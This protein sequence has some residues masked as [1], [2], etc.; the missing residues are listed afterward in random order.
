MKKETIQ[1]QPT[2]TLLQSY[3]PSNWYLV[4]MV[5]AISLGSYITFYTTLEKYPRYNDTVASGLLIL[6]LIYF[7]LRFL[8][9]YNFNFYQT[10]IVAYQRIGNKRL[11]IPYQDIENYT[12]V[13]KKDK[14]RINY[15]LHFKTIDNQ[16]FKICS[17]YCTYPKAF[18]QIYKLVKKEAKKDIN[19]SNKIQRSERRELAYGLILVSSL[20]LFLNYEIY[21]D[22]PEQAT[23]KNTVLI[24]GTVDI[25]EH[26]KQRSHYWYDLKLIE[27]P[28]FSFKIDDNVYRIL[29]SSKIFKSDP[30]RPNDTLSLNITQK[31]YEYKIAQTK[32]PSWKDF[33]GDYNI[34]E[35]CSIEKKSTNTVYYS[36]QDYINIGG[37][38]QP[39]GKDFRLL[40]I[41]MLMVG[42]G[43][44]FYNFDRP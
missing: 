17:R 13:E 42:L 18:H 6:T 33:F 2:Y 31:D 21:Q 30:I 4:G 11:V 8:T 3:R 15:V 10:H 44:L 27:Y 12:I 7:L 28:D 43:I 35:P 38:S 19:C 20:L 41:I 24:N 29:L 32:Q 39:N 5:T 23:T 40:F 16:Y 36:I 22:I 37:F 1:N 14:D 34:I 9:Q 26:R 25:F